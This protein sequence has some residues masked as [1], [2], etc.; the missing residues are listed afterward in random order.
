MPKY[1]SNKSETFLY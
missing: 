1:L